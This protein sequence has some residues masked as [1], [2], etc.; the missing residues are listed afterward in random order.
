MLREIVLDTETTGFEP[1]EG[2]RIVEIGCIE[3]L[4]RFPTGR[5]FH[6]YL[7]PDRDMPDDAF[8]VHGL[9]TEFLADKP[10]FHEVHTEFLTFLGD[11]KIVIHNA[12]FDTKFLNH[13]FGLCGAAAL[14]PERIVDTLSLARRKHPN[15]SNS[16]D[17][18]C[19]RYGLDRSRRIKHGALLDAE[20]LAEVYSELLGGKQ[21]RLDLR[22][23]GARALG[24]N[25]GV[26]RTRTN[27]LEPRLTDA[28]RAA[29]AAFVE[30]L[31]PDA[32][33]LKYLPRPALVA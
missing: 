25:A 1:S 11:A 33:W 16:L 12:A 7:N 19:D 9:S 26:P 31:G 8:R 10:R 15:A 23:A 13:E 14:S 29:H 2:H 6:V 3:L 22:T 27:P 17:A 21:S 20:I 28:E 30:T 32:I 5:T 4:D 24:Q 18:L